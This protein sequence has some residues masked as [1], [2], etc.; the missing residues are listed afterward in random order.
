MEQDEEA[1]EER[2][3]SEDVDDLELKLL[4]KFD[5]WDHATQYVQEYAR[6]K[7]FR[8]CVKERKFTDRDRLYLQLM[9]YQCTRAGKSAAAASS[10]RRNRTSLRCE[11]PYSISIG[12]TAEGVVYVS[13]LRDEHN[14]E[15]MTKEQVEDEI[16]RRRSE[17]EQKREI[18]ALSETSL[19][20]KKIRDVIYA[21]FSTYRLP[22]KTIHNT[23]SYYRKH[24]T[25]AHQLER[26]SRMLRPSVT[27]KARYEIL[28]DAARRYC[29]RAVESEESYE[30]SKQDLLALKHFIHRPIRQNACVLAQQDILT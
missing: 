17:E 1:V 23:V 9:R 21:K 22:Y 12:L 15:M 4:T 10:S 25:T 20:V 30:K 8:L 11:C 14:H 16:Q 28:I 2:G 6:Q 26:Q 18:Q 5:G 27:K 29:S 19:S 13:Q 24:V 3:E 7:G